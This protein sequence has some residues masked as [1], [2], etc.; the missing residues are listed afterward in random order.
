VLALP[1]PSCAVELTLTAT[2]TTKGN[3]VIAVTALNTKTNKKVVLLGAARVTISAGRSKT[4]RSPR[5]P[6]GQAAALKAARAKDEAHYHPVGRPPQ[7]H[8]V[9]QDNHFQTK[10]PKKHGR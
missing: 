1:R 8:R 2:E 6:H 3:E 7:H 9:H 4:I 5:Q 10:P